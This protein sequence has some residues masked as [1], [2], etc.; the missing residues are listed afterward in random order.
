MQRFGARGKNPSNEGSSPEWVGYLE[1]GI[2]RSADPTKTRGGERVGA[3][4]EAPVRSEDGGRAPGAPCRRK[5]PCRFR[6]F[7]SPISRSVRE[8]SGVSRGIEPDHVRRDQGG[9]PFRE[10]KVAGPQ[11]ERADLRAVVE[12]RGGDSAGLAAKR[13]PLDEPPVIDEQHAGRRHPARLKGL[14]HR[15]KN[16]VG[17]ATSVENARDCLEH[18]SLLDRAV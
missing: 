10:V 12:N 13:R 14:E 3:P 5:A 7:A 17:I 8:S 18:G 11:L 1:R 4:A 15:P 16:N 9:H 6:G 2:A